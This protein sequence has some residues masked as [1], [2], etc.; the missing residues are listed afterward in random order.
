MALLHSV[1]VSFSGASGYNITSGNEVVD[2]DVLVY[3]PYYNVNDGS[4]IITVTG[5][6]LSSVTPYELLT[7]S[8][9]LHW[10]SSSVS[11]TSAV[12]SSAAAGTGLTVQNSIR[13]HNK[14][15]VWTTIGNI[16]TSLQAPALN[17]TRNSSYVG[18][19]TGGSSIVKVA[20]GEIL[21]FTT[22][23]TIPQGTLN[24][25]VVTWTLPNRLTG[26]GT[27]GYLVATDSA[28]TSIGS[29]ITTSNLTSANAA[30]TL[31]DSNNDGA[32][33]TVVFDFGTTVNVADYVVNSGDQITL[34]ITVFV[35]NVSAN[36]DGR[37]LVSNCTVKAGG[38][39]GVGVNSVSLL[40]IE[41]RLTVGIASN[42]TTGNG[43]DVVVFTVTV[44]HI[45]GVSTGSGYDVS[46]EL[47]SLLTNKLRLVGG[48][49]TCGAA[50]SGAAV[51]GIVSGS[52]SGDVIVRSVIPAYTL[53]DGALT[54]RFSAVIESSVLPADVL[55]A[56]VNLRYIS[57]PNAGG[58]G[59]A[60]D[61]Y[62]ERT[63][64]ATSTISSNIWSGYAVAP[65]YVYSTSVAETQF[66]NVSIGETVTYRV[67]LVIPEGTTPYVN[68]TVTFPR[69]ITVIDSTI[70]STGAAITCTPS[71]SACASG[72]TG[73]WITSTTKYDGVVFGFGTVTNTGDNVID[74]ADVIV[75]SVTGVISNSTSNKAGTLLASNGTLQYSIVL[76][77]LV[78]V[79]SVLLLLWW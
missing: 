46:L 42:V 59:S 39:V 52:T 32:K 29:S 64:T 61:S 67:E 11:G 6:A 37:S 41:P 17:V 69:G 44:D 45:A 30:G 4:I 73:T 49:V 56:T 76:I 25:L 16:I 70:V 66:S 22:T 27:G 19:L 47:P 77:Q 9:V 57:Y 18:D 65:L 8:T 51:C 63:A 23:A 31:V 2:R 13:S 43:G 75:L 5:R 10:S 21:H 58:S 68:Y 36:I 12:L 38:I 72:A 62:R 15:L 74:G 55:S 3:I 79:K 28:V 71:P 40:V 20:I 14:G 7:T 54:L 33:D 50:N 60:L 34:R 53:L 78:L 35:A 24:S 26:T 48:S 1:T